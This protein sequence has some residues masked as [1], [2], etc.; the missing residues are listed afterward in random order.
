MMTRT[1]LALPMTPWSTWSA[2]RCYTWTCPGKRTRGRQ[3]EQQQQ[4]LVVVVVVVVVPLVLGGAPLLLPLMALQRRPVELLGGQQRG[5]VPTVPTPPA[6]PPLPQ[7][8]RWQR[9]LAY[10]T[11]GWGLRHAVCTSLRGTLC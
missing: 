2:L 7:K 3:Q 9:A 10:Q 1:A 5:V 4:Q 8:P 6:A 11:L